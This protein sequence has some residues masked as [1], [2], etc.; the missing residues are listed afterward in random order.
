MADA[1]RRV[2][3]AGRALAE[4]GR[5]K[6]ALVKFTQALTIDPSNVEIWDEVVFSRQELGDHVGM[7]AAADEMVGLD[8]R[9]GRGHYWRAYALGKLNRYAEALDSARQ[10]IQLEPESSPAWRCLA[11]HSQLAGDLAQAREAATRA[12]E[13]DPGYSN[14]WSTAGRLA[15][16]TGDFA[17]AEQLL[18][19][20]LSIDPMNLKAHAELIWVIDDQGRTEEAITLT[21]ELVALEPVRKPSNLD[22]L[23]TRLAEAGKVDHAC[24]LLRIG[25]A[26]RPDYV[27]F[28]TTLVDVLR[29]ADRREE[30]LAMARDAVA[31]L[32]DEADVW[33]SLAWT[34]PYGDPEQVAATGRATTLNPRSSWAWQRH[35]SALWASGDLAGAADAIRQAA[36]VE[37]GDSHDQAF[38]ARRLRELGELTGALEFADRAVAVAPGKAVPHLRRAA[39][40]ASLGRLDEA[41]AAARTATELAPDDPQVW[42][43]RAEV[44]LQAGDVAEARLAAERTAELDNP[45]LAAEVAG[46]AAWVRGDRDASHAAY[47]RALELKAGSCCSRLGHA[48][49]AAPP[50]AVAELESLVSPTADAFKD[51]AGCYTVGCW[52]RAQVLDRIAEQTEKRY[53]R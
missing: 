38:A 33:S 9:F 11:Y 48:L 7:L 16:L 37:P 28:R 15:R 12:C 44:A 40:L 17:E 3:A 27:D 13:L 18:R 43:H 14:A 35:S 29:A 42:Y 34:L 46:I 5:H 51:G 36:A 47:A 45:H 26:A 50:P 8:P 21:R 22:D 41:L 53:P 1:V 32:P 39:A 24:E 30:A 52:L 4:W 20:A 6:D 2:M 10:A 23:A 19:Q 25:I 31:A 49:T